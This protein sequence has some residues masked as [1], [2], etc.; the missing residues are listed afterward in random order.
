MRRV[1]IMGAGGRDFHDFNVVYRDDPKTEVVAFTASQIPGIDDRRYP[2]SL[3]GPRYPEGIPIR[4]E[5]ELAWL[6]ETY[7]VDEVILAYSD[8]SHEQVMHKASLVLATGADFKLLGPH[9]TMLRS[10][11]PVIAVGAVRTG[12]GKSQTSRRIGQILVDSRLE[13]RGRAASDAVRR[14]RGDACPAVRHAGGHRRDPSDDRRARG[15][16]APGR[17]RDGRVRRRG[18]RRD[19]RAGRAGG[20]R[21]RLGRW[22]QRLPVLHA[23]PLRRGGRPAQAGARAQVPPRRDE[24]ADG[25]RRRRE[26]GRLGD[27]RAGGPRD[28]GGA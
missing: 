2:A 11:K 3:A 18:L 23:R 25:R 27:T 10:K 5:A 16:R 26:Q 6:V 9:A 20:R 8:L 24:P 4:P 17:A 28:R 21:H 7:K 13:G 14:P 1:I 22:Q 19:P 12:A 15:V